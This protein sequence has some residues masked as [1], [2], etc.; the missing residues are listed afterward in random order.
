[1][2]TEK[3]ICGQFWPRAVVRETLSVNL[4]NWL[5]HSFGLCAKQKVYCTILAQFLHIIHFYSP[6]CFKAELEEWL[7]LPLLYVLYLL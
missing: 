6:S 5:E 2:L 3:Y 1:M 7:V 4:W